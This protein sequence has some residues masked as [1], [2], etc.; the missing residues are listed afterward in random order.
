M[1]EWKKLFDSKE[2]GRGK[3]LFDNNWVMITQMTGTVVRAEVY[4]ASQQEV[5]IVQ[6]DG[7]PVSM[8]CSCPKSKG[9]RNCEHIAAVFFALYPSSYEQLSLVPVQKKTVTEQE[10]SQKESIQKKKKDSIEEYRYYDMEKLCKIAQISE[11]SLQKGRK[12]IENKEIRLDQLHSGYADTDDE[13][14]VEMTCIADYAKGKKGY[15]H[16][17][18]SRKQVYRASCECPSCR[19]KSYYWDTKQKCEHV[20]GAFLLAER[21]IIRRQIGDETDRTASILLNMFSKKRAQGVI[22]QTQQMQES[23]RLEPRVQLLEEGFYISFKVGTS[24]MYIVKDL[25]DFADAVK[26]CRTV[27]YG[28]DTMLNHQKENF[29]QEAWKWLEFIERAV[30]EEL[31]IEARIN[32]RYWGYSERRLKCDDLELYGWRLDALFEHIKDSG[33]EYEDKTLR[34]KY[35]GV[36]QTAD[37]NPKVVMWIAKSKIST[38]NK[39]E[40]IDVSCKI[41]EFYEGAENSYYLE[42]NILCKV[43]KEFGE[44][45]DMLVSM[46][47][48][49]SLRFRVGRRK[50][51]E[52]YYTFLPQIEDVVEIVEKDK[53]II[54]KYL[55]PE[56]RFVFYL[57]QV[58]GNIECQV[59]AVYG[60]RELSILDLIDHAED[61]VPEAFRMLQ[62]EDEVLCQV[63]QFFTNYDAEK[64]VV[65]CGGDETK[66]YEVLSHGVDVLAT[67]GEVR[68]TQAFKKLNVIHK[69]PVSVGVSLSGEDG[70][71]NLEVSSSEFTPKELLEILAGYR[72]RRKYFRLKSGDFVNLEEN[73]SVEMLEE[74]MNTLHLSAKEFTKGKMHIP[75]YRALYMDKLLEENSEVYQTRDKHFKDLIRN[76]KTVNESDFEEPKS[77]SKLMRNYQKNGYKWLR[78]LES[79]G[80]G[81][82]LA[83][84]M[85]LGKTLQ[86]IAVLLA[87]KEENAQAARPS[88]IISPSSLVYNWKEEFARFAPQL[89][90]ETV[91]GTQEERR[92]L[93][94]EYESHDVLITSYDL[95]KRDIA[96]YEGKSFAYQII[97][98]AQYIKN[99]TTAAAKSVK[100][101]RSRI[102]YA[103]TGTPIENRLS[104][105]WSIFDFLMPGFLYPYETFKREIE[106]PIVRSADE[107]VTKRIQRMVAPFILRRLKQDVL[108]DLPDKLEETRYVK[109]EGEQKQLHDAQVTYIQELLAKQGDEEFQKNKLRVLAELTK[110]RQICCDPNLCYENYHGESA[111]LESCLDLVESAIDGGHKILLFSQFT[112][113]LSILE[114]RLEKQGISYYKITGETKKEVRL[115][116]VK[117]FNEDDTEVFLISLKAGGVGLNL[118]GA[119]VVI[120]YDPWWNV[121]AQNQATDRAHRIGQEKKVTVYKLIIKQSVEEKILKLQEMKKDLADKVINGETGQLSALSKEELLELLDA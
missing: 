58:Q 8:R 72:T 117:Q 19:N 23:I 86:S 115:Q 110:L 30:E 80:F 74:L 102:R 42:K 69:V 34:E 104:E 120:H 41:P 12:L 44:R 73:D 11:E 5:A 4:G 7:K 50:L 111:K 13:Q 82:I 1:D 70:M 71:M 100:L 94:N 109:V 90:V 112:S 66:I 54:G 43:N 2:L 101:I 20:A 17:V 26:A 77:L 88:L 68:C 29:V 65:H 52:F 92:K 55:P 37:R 75:A 96:L 3:R 78:M 39:F 51:Q 85:G 60:A 84:D 105:L 9:G 40:G 16:L 64:D 108:K 61:V 15:V 25:I 113:M 35:K 62:R 95:L 114:K 118:T 93:L 98:E 63:N 18:F 56:V 97:D 31:R 57:D 45:I 119:D 32:S 59:H 27:K 99:Q 79:C 48:N 107:T 21:E 106:T 38:V 28:K 46:S 53:E 33:C 49:D 89:I 24:R 83:D 116:L 36:L 14:A 103:L 6:K 76:F 22:A 81:G 47:E 10:K 67:L 87:Y 121:A 91:T